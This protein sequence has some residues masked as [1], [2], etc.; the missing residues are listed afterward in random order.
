MKYRLLTEQE[1]APLQ[2]EFL[3]YLLVANITPQSWD[4]LKQNNPKE[5]QYHLEVFSDLVLD[6]IL[7]EVSYVDIVLENRVEVYHFMQDQAYLFS[8]E[9]KVLGTFDYKKNDWSSLDLKTTNLVKGKKSYSK[10]KN[11]EVFEILN[12]PHAFI[13]S[14][15]LYKKIALLSVGV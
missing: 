15:D 3:K 2:E 4:I 13:S 11:K 12:K 6:K 14:G 9:N 8:I 1:L 10:E 7:S 5:S